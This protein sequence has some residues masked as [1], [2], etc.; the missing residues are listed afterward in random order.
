MGHERYKRPHGVGGP[1]RIPKQAPGDPYPPKNIPQ[2]FL[3]MVWFIFTMTPVFMNKL[4]RGELALTRR[5][6]KKVSS[7][8]HLS[9]SESG[10]QDESPHQDDYAHLSRQVYSL[11]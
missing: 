9:I 2:R 5:R 3:L 1:G 6:V 4:R 10:I 7:V 11:L 8:F